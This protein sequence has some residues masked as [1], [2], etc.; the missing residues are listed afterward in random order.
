MN[1]TD[2]RGDEEKRFVRSGMV[3]FDREAVDAR[4][5]SIVRDRQCFD[6]SLVFE[7]QQKYV[8]SNFADA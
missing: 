3:S 8:E 4:I 1:Q 2:V 7:V 5:R 6:A